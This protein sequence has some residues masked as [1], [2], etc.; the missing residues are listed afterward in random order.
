MER[1]KMHHDQRMVG[2]WEKTYKHRQLYSMLP[3]QAN[4]GWQGTLR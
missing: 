2:I 4:A 3:I 1:G